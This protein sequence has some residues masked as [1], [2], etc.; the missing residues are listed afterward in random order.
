MK[1]LRDVQESAV[2][3]LRQAGLTLADAD[4]DE[5]LLV[6]V[7]DAELVEDEDEIGA[8]RYEVDATLAVT[9]A[10]ATSLAVLDALSDAHSA[11]MG[12]ATLSGAAQSLAWQGYELDG[13]EG[14]LAGT[15]TYT[16]RF[17]RID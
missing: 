12:D 9:S 5:G 4:A 14:V 6:T 3:A 16:A 15:A 2:R 7:T 13:D 8:G 1:Q 10:G 11:L 17:T